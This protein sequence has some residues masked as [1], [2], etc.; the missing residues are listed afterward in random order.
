M[1][2]HEDTTDLREAFLP[3]TENEMS[4]RYL[5]MMEKWIP[6]GVEYFNTWP[7]RPNCGH[8]FGGCHAYGLETIWPAKT[9]ALA[10]LASEYDQS[11]G[12][13]SQ[14]ELREMAIK[15]VRYLCFT[16]DTGPED[17]VRPATGLG[18]SKH[19]N[20]KWGEKGTGF[21]RESQCGTVVATLGQICL[22]LRP[23]IDEETW[24]MVARIHEDYAERFADMPPKNGIYVDTQMEENMWT[25]NGLIGCFLF[26]SGHEKAAEWEI[27]AR[28]WMFS[29][30][31]APQDAKDHGA[32]GLSTAHQLSFK[33]FTALPDYWAENHGMVHPGYTASGVRSLFMGGV[34]HKLWGREIPPEI[35]WNRKRIYETMKPLTDG[36]GYPQAVQGM[37]WHYLPATGSDV[38]HAIASVFF[39]DE[40]AATLQRI[41]LRNSELRQ[42]GNNGR[43][44]DKEFAHKAHDQQDP[45]I[46]RETTIQ[47]T[48][49]SYLLHKV[50]GPGA[51]PISEHDLSDRLK[52]VRTFHHGGFTHHRHPQGQTSFSW[53]NSIMA[54]PLTKEGIFTI[55]P[56]AD[57]WLGKPEVTNAPESHRLKSVEITEYDEAFSA[58]MIMDRCQE[59][60]RQYVLFSSLPDGRILSFEKFVAQRDLELLSLN[61]G[62]LRII[63]ETFPL[64]AQENNGN[65]RGSRVFYHN[66]GQTQNDGWLGEE[67]SD[68]VISTFEGLDWV[69]I[70][71]RMGIRFESDGQ[72]VYNNR[73]FYKPYRAIGDDLTLSCTKAPKILSK[74]DLTGQLAALLIPEQGHDQTPDSNLIISTVEP[75]QV[76]LMTDGYLTVGNFSDALKMCQLDFPASSH[77]PIFGGTTLQIQPD[78]LTYL[79]QLQAQTSCI[80]EQIHT[81]EVEGQIRVDTLQDGTLYVVNTGQTTA[82]VRLLNDQPPTQPTT[83]GP[84]EVLKLC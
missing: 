35:Y 36:G 83:I 37:D 6:T 69:N 79:V 71:D 19:C 39:D 41:G 31:S 5:R 25:A 22:L 59:S 23:H 64:Y 80:L 62:F 30:C 17:C 27:S 73:H 9:F 55:G 53:R 49:G 43:L 58:L 15:A 77:I 3:D 1:L 21:F 46:I 8:F 50:M 78:R 32:V 82:S 29:T 38:T 67:E 52:G 76:G 7:E 14:E 54:M 63:N 13:A 33:T 18:L 68:D 16:H 11:V 12:G 2:H 81:L 75:D 56:C 26:L 10:S 65:C 70:D 74:N 84:N 40:E 44:Y 34:Q 28:K 20:T 48:C 66:Q 57:T 72:T 4:R 61:Q 42:D 45:M 60:L 47:H 24:M 51:N